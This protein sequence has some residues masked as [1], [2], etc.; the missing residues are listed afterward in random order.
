MEFRFDRKEPGVWISAGTHV[1]LLALALFS[2]AAPALP[3]EPASAP[4][5]CRYRTAPPPVGGVDVVGLGDGLLVEVVGDG[6][7]PP[8]FA[9]PP[10]QFC[11]PAAT[12]LPAGTASTLPSTPASSSIIRMPRGRQG[13]TTPGSSGYG[14]ITST[15]TGSP[16]PDRVCGT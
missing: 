10:D 6:L 15:S 3:A 1:T 2:V 7:T 11:A 13:T 12:V 14:A 8:P 16:S 5:V 4:P 9:L